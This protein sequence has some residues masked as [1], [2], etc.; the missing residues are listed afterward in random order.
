[1]AYD[2]GEYYERVED[3]DLEYQSQS[4]LDQPFWRELVMR[5]TPQRVLEL[6]CGS[7]RIGLDLLHSPGAFQLEGLDVAPAMLAAYQRKLALESAEIQQRVTLHQGDMATY[8][9]EH[10]GTYDLILLPFNSI[11]HLYEL[12]QQLG[13]FRNTFDHLAPN[14]RFVVDIF[15]PDI[16]YLSDA[17]NRPSHVYLEDEIESPDGDFTMLLYSSRKYDPFEQLQHLVGTHEKFFETGDNERYLTKLDMH[18]F[19]PRELQLLFLATG[20][21]IEAIYGDYDW[22]PFGKGTRQIVVGRKQH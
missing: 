14:G 8:N 4:E 20:F 9:L 5:Y 1:M 15:L 16:D 3:Y 10:K 18:V 12:E 22:K 13:T 6:A 21:A 17:L 11:T 7:G 19:F 2:M